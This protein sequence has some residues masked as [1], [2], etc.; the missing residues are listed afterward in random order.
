MKVS[1]NDI[2][3]SSSNDQVN[4]RAIRGGT[5]RQLKKEKKQIFFIVQ[6]SK[7]RGNLV[8]IWKGEKVEGEGSGIEKGRKW[9]A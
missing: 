5:V 6:I 9:K 1:T 3:N 7:Y 4:D 2:P 8:Y